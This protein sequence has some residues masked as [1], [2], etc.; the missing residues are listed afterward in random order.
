M[1]TIYHW[2]HLPFTPFISSMR[3]A[4]SLP[5]QIVSQFFVL[6][7][8]R[9]NIFGPR[10]KT[11][12]ANCPDLQVFSKLLVRGHLSSFFVSTSERVKSFGFW[13]KTKIVSILRLFW[14]VPNI[15]ERLVVSDEGIAKSHCWVYFI[16][17]TLRIVLQSYQ[18]CHR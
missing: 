4:V 13:K 1:F 14:K 16:S 17:T 7:Q 10:K 18:R 12:C 15:V 2:H 8:K 6:S 9:G 11:C 3:D 5:M